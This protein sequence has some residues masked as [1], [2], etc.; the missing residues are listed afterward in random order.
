MVILMQNETE[1]SDSG[2][3]VVGHLF[4]LTRY[5]LP[6]RQNHVIPSR[7][8][9]GPYVGPNGLCCHRE[10]AFLPINEK[11]LAVVRSLHF[12]RAQRRDDMRFRE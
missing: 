3:G 2:A 1:N 10:Y 8:G 4:K 6:Q 5:P 9:E 11:W 7:F 12:R